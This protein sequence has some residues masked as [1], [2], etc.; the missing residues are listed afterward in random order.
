MR[1]PVP[2]RLRAV[3]RRWSVMFLVVLVALLAGGW[4]WLSRGDDS[5]TQRITATVARGT[6]KTTVSA[7]G[8]IT[9]RREE[10]LSFSSAG[11]VTRV[12]VAVGDKVE[13]GDVLAAIGTAS[14][15]A[16]LDAA[17]A[18]VT[19]ATTQLSEDSGASSTQ[20]TADRASL[21]S[22][23]SDLEQAQDALDAATLRA[24]FSG[25]VSAVGYEVG[26]QAGSSGNG[27]ADGS[28]STAAITV[29]SPRALQV[30][31]NVSAADV[32]QLRTGLQVEITPI[33]DGEPAF[34]TVTEV[35]VIATASD[36]GAAQFP[37]TVEVTGRPKGLYAGSSASL[38]ITVKQASD[39]LAVSTAALHSDGDQTFVYVIDGTRRTKQVVTVGETYGA[40]TE[41]LSGLKEGDVVELVS[42]TAPTSK[43]RNGGTNDFQL[44]GGGKAP[45]GGQGPVLIQQGG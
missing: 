9:P 34:G 36:S 33:G 32:S 44:P 22:A 20:L 39:V 29:I 18:Q 41:V 28:G 16:Q 25:T 13:K 1:L 30:D 26:D 43:N 3:P 35:G 40:Q 38:A 19:A 4:T 10:D 7:T 11:T 5:D 6:Y 8:T 27:N 14:L 31:A 21:A 24:P 15:Q 42:F 12:P 2:S 23:R 37:V 17:R 45:G